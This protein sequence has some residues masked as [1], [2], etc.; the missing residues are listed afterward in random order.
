VGIEANDLITVKFVS[1]NTEN[2][3]IQG[4]NVETVDGGK[5]ASKAI[6]GAIERV[7][8][9]QAELGAIQSRMGFVIQNAQIT[10]ENTK[11]SRATF[12]DV[13]FGAEVTIFTSKQTLSQA[14]AS[15]S[16]QA[17]RIPELFLQMLQG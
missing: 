14:A 11:S 9:A 10:L 17:N 4:L 5:D 16:A 15:M 3:G 12:T 2:L 1:M 7:G 6:D 8:K 13:D